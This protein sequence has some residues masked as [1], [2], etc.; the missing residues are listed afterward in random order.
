[1]HSPGTATQRRKAATGVRLAEIAGAPVGFYLLK[2]T[3]LMLH[4]WRA[5]QGFNDAAYAESEI[6]SFLESFSTTGF[7]RA[8]AAPLRTPNR[9]S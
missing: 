4:R 5:V 1:V 2:G 8:L 3:E 6:M 7:M 9:K